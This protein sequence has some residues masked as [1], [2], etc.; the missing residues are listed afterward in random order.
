M[1]LLKY[2]ER[3]K[4]MHDLIHRKATG[5]PDEF[6][7]KLGISKSM[8]MINLAELKEMGAPLQYNNT[9]HTYLYNEPCTLRFGFELNMHD[10]QKIKGGRHNFY[11]DLSHYNNI[12]TTF[13]SFTVQGF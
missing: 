8:L 9:T 3:L 6:A 1:S 4:R 11:P 12:R 7:R 2:V 13:F 5:T 10:S